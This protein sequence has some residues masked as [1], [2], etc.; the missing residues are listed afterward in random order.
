MH[1]PVRP[2]SSLCCSLA[3]VVAAIQ[4]SIVA[5]ALGQSPASWPQFHGPNRDNLSQDTGLL[6]E[7][8]EGGPELLWTAEKLGYGYSSVA[9]GGGAIYTA[10]NIEGRTVITALD[11]EGQMLWQV[12]NGAAWEGSYPGTRGTPTIDGNRL[13]H[14]NPLGDVVCLE[15]KTGKKIWGTNILDKFGSKNIRWALAES[16]LIDGD[17]VVC[18]PG[19]S[20]ASLVALHKMTGETIWK[21]KSTG[22]PASYASPILVEHDGLR[23]IITLTLR[24]I[25]GVNADNGELLWRTSHRTWFDEN[26]LQ[27][28]YRDGCV[29]VSSL[30]AG[31]VKW[32]IHV[33][34]QE[35]SLEEV[36]KSKQLDNQHGG[37]VL[38]GGYLYGSSCLFNRG[39]WICLDWETGERQYAEKGVGKGALTYADGKL[40]TLSERY[41]VGLVEATPEAHRLVSQFRLPE[42]GKGRSWAHP[43]VFGGRL[44]IRHGDFL[45]AFD[46]AA[47]Q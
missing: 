13:Y 16:L 2:K 31:S 7:W 34:G 20:E 35:A 37:V 11:M 32:R 17:R 40:Y 28:I 27:P 21:A 18:C 5:A 3:A 6:K 15:T 29:F 1:R 36:W 38:V 14:E 19:G 46:V 10:G 4:L 33:K 42:G 41:I 39:R 8:P 24:A 45:Y 25:V 22:D 26:V 30:A 9:I 23:M 43:V 47:P 12:E 44:Y